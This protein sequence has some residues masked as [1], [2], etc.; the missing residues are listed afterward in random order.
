[1]SSRQLRPGHVERAVVVVGVI[2]AFEIGAVGVAVVVVDAAGH[3]PQVGGAGEVQAIEMG[4]G[5]EV[6]VV[7]EV[8]D[9]PIGRGKTRVIF[10]IAGLGDQA[11]QGAGMA[12]DLALPGAFPGAG[13]VGI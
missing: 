6:H 5:A 13:D 4:F 11:A 10:V 1:M 8:E 12:A 7:A 9:F 3:F 2:R